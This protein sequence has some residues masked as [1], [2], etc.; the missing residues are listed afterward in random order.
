MVP[1]LLEVLGIE[2][3]QTIKGVTQSPIE[4]VSF[5]HT[6][7]GSEAATKK[8]TQYYEMFGQR[9]LWYDGWKA[10]CNYPFGQPV[11]DEGLSQQKWELYRVDPDG[12]E[13]VDRAEMNDVADKYPEILRAL[14]ARWWSEAEE[15]NVLPL[16]GGEVARIANAMEELGVPERE[17]YV[18][19][20]DTPEIPETGAV[21]LK[22]R[23]H[24]IT[25]E[26]TIP[27]DGAEGVLLAH[28]GLTGGYS[29]YMQDGKLHYVHNFLGLAKYYVH[30]DAV[31]P[32]GE[33]TLHFE[34]EKTGEHQGQGKLYINGNQ[35]GEAE[36]DRTVPNNFGINEGLTCGYD[37]GLPVIDDYPTPFRFTGTIKRVVV[38]PH[39]EEQVDHQKELEIEMSKE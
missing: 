35:V 19:Y 38:I 4:G 20:P 16:Q 34:F 29:F 18:Y 23:S 15:F 13:P 28:G 17:K 6:L 32:S 25:A 8:E 27:D 5:A 14:K 39:G 12:P 30:S 3:P 9:A 33:C 7:N 37:N 36:I 1:T 11:T 10:I 24:S 22:N 31:V 21:N 26:V 2:P